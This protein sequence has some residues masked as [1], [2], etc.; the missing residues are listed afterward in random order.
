[1]CASIVSSLTNLRRA[2]APR[3]LTQSLPPI[4][5]GVPDPLLME[6]LSLAERRVLAPGSEL[7]WPDDKV[8]EWH[9]LQMGCV[10]C[11]TLEQVGA[12]VGV[13]VCGWG[14]GGWAGVCCATLGVGC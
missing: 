4:P 14:G 11:A 7:G 8:E 13:C 3:P 10:C 1:M 6:F 5:P 9:L 2:N 12:Q